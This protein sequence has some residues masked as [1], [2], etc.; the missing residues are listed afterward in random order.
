MVRDAGAD[1]VALWDVACALEDMCRLV[2]AMDKYIDTAS[3]R[4]CLP[5][6]RPPPWSVVVF[7]W[8]LLGPEDGGW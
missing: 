6:R 1:A 2:D 8:S 5:A 4:A 3:L 7:A